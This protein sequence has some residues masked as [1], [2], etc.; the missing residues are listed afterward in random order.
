MHS[1]RIAWWIFWVHIQD[2]SARQVVLLHVPTRCKRGLRSAVRKMGFAA[3]WSPFLLKYIIEIIFTSPV[4][5]EILQ[6]FSIAYRDHWS[7]LHY[8]CLTSSRRY[9]LLRTESSPSYRAIMDDALIIWRRDWL[10]C[11]SLNNIEACLRES[12]PKDLEILQVKMQW[13][14]SGSSIFLSIPFVRHKGAA[15]LFGHAE[16]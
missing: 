13:S 2:I 14:C 5:H 6:Y 11:S 4:Y 16:I 8:P 1:V 7:Y 12:K 3:C 15:N 9:H 10:R